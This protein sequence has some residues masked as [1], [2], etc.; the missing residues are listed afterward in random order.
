MTR[1]EFAREVREAVY[2]DDEKLEELID[3]FQLSDVKKKGP[4]KETSDEVSTFELKHEL[5][6][7][8]ETVVQDTAADMY[9]REME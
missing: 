2:I 9:H 1:T 4:L 8:I 3:G 6:D 5:M 7:H